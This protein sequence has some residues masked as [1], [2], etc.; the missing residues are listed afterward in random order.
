MKLLYYVGTGSNKFGGLEKFNI[1]LFKILLKNGH[2]IVVVYRRPIVAGPFRSFLDEYDIKYG[3]LNDSFEIVNESK[4]RNAKKLACFIKKENPDLVH[5][6]FGNI[7]DIVISKLLN[8]GVKYKAIYT[9]HCHPDLKNKYIKSVFG[10][11]S[12]FV[13]KILCVSRAIDT[14]FRERLRTKKAQ[15]LYLGVYPNKYNREIERN[16]YGFKPEEVI[17]CNIAYHDPVKG[18]DVLLKAAD[19]LK[20]QL[21][22]HNFRIIQIGGSPFKDSSDAIKSLFDKLNIE[23]N[24][25]FW[26]LRNDIEKIMAASDIYCQPSR[27]EGIPLSIME[28]GMAGLPVVATNVGGIPEAAYNNENA[29]ITKSEDFISIA[30]NLKKLIDDSLLRKQMGLRGERI[31]LNNFNIEKQSKRLHDIYISLL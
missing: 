11:I 28:A 21:N 25:E 14:E 9:S 15:C 13:K 17:I 16:K 1:E 10:G 30:I 18:V 31:A 20:R 6:N 29:L 23:D 3:W 12:L 4:I 5:F 22:T 2:E 8:P 19:H 7:Y 26:G 24:F 27:S